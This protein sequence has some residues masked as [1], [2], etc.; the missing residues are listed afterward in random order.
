MQPVYPHRAR[1]K[2]IEAYVIVEFSVSAPGSTDN[3]IV[4]E[5][6]PEQIFGRAAIR[7]ASKPRFKPAIVEGKPLAVQVF[8]KIYLQV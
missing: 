4:L 2:G 8:E 3:I 5:V 1:Q 7:A 6:Y